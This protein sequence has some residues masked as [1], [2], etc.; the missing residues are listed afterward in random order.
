MA[1]G[2]V[3]HLVQGLI[4]LNSN[5]IRASRKCR[6]NNKTILVATLIG[7]VFRFM[8]IFAMPQ[9]TVRYAK[10]KKI[11]N[12]WFTSSMT[13]NWVVDFYVKVS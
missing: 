6:S 4:F 5:C 13:F 3:D 10:P 2:F 12:F 11:L 7:I 8:I 1:M 9:K